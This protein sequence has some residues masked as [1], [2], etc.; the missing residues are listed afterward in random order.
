MQKNYLANPMPM[1]KKK[2]NKLGIEGNFPNMIKD[3]YKKT[4][5]NIIIE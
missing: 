5:A 3:V 2:V 1:I 4:T